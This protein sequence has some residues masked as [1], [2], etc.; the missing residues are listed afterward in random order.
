MC[1]IDADRVRQIR[2]ELQMQTVT[3]L[4]PT[5]PETRPTMEID[6]TT[7]GTD[8]PTDSCE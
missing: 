1:R 6:P 5:M 2:E 3:T 8:V 7:P 4:P